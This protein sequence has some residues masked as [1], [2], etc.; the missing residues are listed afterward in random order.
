VK[1]HDEYKGAKQT[2]VT[3]CAVVEV[4]DMAAA[5]VLAAPKVK[6]ARARKGKGEAT[7][8]ETTTAGDAGG[9]KE[10]SGA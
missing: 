1:K 7:A 4:A 3:R 2:I 6:G 9:G 8:G 10:V 5:A